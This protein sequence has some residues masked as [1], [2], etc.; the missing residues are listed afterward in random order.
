LQA[1][2]PV[3]IQFL[4]GLHRFNRQALL[5][6]LYAVAKL[7]GAISLIFVW[8]VYGAFAGF[9]V[10]GV[11]AGLLGWWWTWSVGERGHKPL[12]LRSF[13]QFGGTY[14]LILVGLQLLISLDL[15]MV[16]ALLHEDAQAGYYNAAVTLSRIS[17]MLLQALAFILLP[18]VSA[19]TK[20][21]ASHDEA[22]TFIADAIR[23]L[24]MLIVPSV[25]IAAATTKPLVVLFFSQE[26]LPAAPVLT[27]LMVGI[28][29]LGFYLLLMNIVAGAGKASIGLAV[30]AGMLAVSG[31]LGYWLIPHFGLVGAAW[32]TTV[33]AL[34]GLAILSLY[35]FRTFAI[36]VPVRSIINILI[37]AAV[38]VAPTYFW[39][40]T[41][42]TLP[43]QYVVGAILYGAALFLLREIT[44]A[45]LGRL[46]SIHPRLRFIKP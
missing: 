6:S 16:K 8:H 18:S 46:A 35:T 45:D 5:M 20:P 23:Y 15:F 29:S 21:G 31:L 42:L 27:V 43:L 11:L 12:A 34:L 33:T 19:L 2:Y 40:A 38:G 7:A 17:Y 3:F 41:P 13:L 36:A 22:A 1:Y 9:A 37:A 39:L 26:Y 4:S 14:V 10:G 44:P 32:Q 30:T 25:A 24:I 28:G